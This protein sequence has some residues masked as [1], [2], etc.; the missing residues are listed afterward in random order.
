MPRLLCNQCQ[1]PVGYCYCQHLASVN[2]QW[3]VFFLQDSHEARHPLGTA[4][5]AHL[6]LR[7][8][9]LISINPDSAATKLSLPN[10]AAL[11][12]PSPAARPIAELLDHDVRPLIFLDASWRRARKMMHVFPEL[13]QLPHFQLVEA[14]QSRYRIRKEPSPE[15]VSTL[16]A[17]VTT[18]NLLEFPDGSANQMLNA[19]DWLIDQQID[20]MGQQK[21]TTNYLK[22]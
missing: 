15:S 12:F 16:E 14:G 2:N 19:M 7:Q 22:E 17:V 1:R 20:R 3:P 18:L 5:I 8:S 21:Y 10:N 6:S 9:T 13:A 11:I 4:R